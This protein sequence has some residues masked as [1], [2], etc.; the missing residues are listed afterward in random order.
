MEKI[1][2]YFFEQAAALGYDA[3]VIFGKPNNYVSRGFKR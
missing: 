3:I 1:I 2:E